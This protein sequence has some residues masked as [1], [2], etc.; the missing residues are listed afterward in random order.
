MRN[1]KIATSFVI[2]L[3]LLLSLSVAIATPVKNTDES[4]V[5]IKVAIYD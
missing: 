2:I 5:I 4:E 1:K 3:F